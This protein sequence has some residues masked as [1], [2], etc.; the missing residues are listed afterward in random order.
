MDFDTLHYRLMGKKG[1]I[2]DMPFGPSTLVFK[3]MGKMFALIGLDDDP[4]RINL[5]CD[6]DFALLL[7]QRYA[8]IIPGYHMNKRHWNT[9]VLDGSVPDDLVL[10]MIDDSYELVVKRLRK[11]DRARLRE[12]TALADGSSRVS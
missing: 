2:E 4:Q 12:S 10:D 11:V 6:P 1:A 7:R 5:K 9:V 3:V 8:G